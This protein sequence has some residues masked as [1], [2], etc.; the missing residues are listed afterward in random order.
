MKAAFQYIASV[1]GEDTEES[2]P[3]KAKVC[4]KNFVKASLVEIFHVLD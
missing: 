3:Y 4:C 1:T 2:Y